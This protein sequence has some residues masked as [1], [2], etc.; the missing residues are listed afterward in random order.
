ML[1]SPVGFRSE[2]DCAS[3]ARQKLKSIDPA[4]NNKIENGKNGHTKTDWSTDCRS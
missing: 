2:K 3:Y 1:M 4:S